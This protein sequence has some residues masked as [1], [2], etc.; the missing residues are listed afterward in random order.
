MSITGVH[1]WANMAEP[2]RGIATDGHCM[3]LLSAVRPQFRASLL[4][5][6]DGD[7]DDDGDWV[8]GRRIP[9]DPVAKSW[10][11]SVEAATMRAT[12]HCGIRQGSYTATLFVRDDGQHVAA[13]AFLVMMLRGAISGVVVAWMQDPKKPLS[14]L[15]AFGVG[16]PV[17]LVMPMRL[18]GDFNLETDRVRVEPD[19]LEL[20]PPP[21]DLAEGDKTT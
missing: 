11:A 12:E 9:P 14:P 3:L 18:P 21:A 16:G 13:S 8:P 5:M 19:V 20:P 4:D 2:T 10:R 17:G 1:W 6:D 7:T 15:V